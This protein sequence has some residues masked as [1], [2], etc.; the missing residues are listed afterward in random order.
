[1]FKIARP[2]WR[3]FRLA[4]AF[5]LIFTNWQILCWIDPKMI[6]FVL[7]FRPTC[8]RVFCDIS[9]EAKKKI[10][11][12]RL[13]YGKLLGCEIKEKLLPREGEKSWLH[14]S[15][16]LPNFFLRSKETKWVDKNDLS[17]W[18]RKWNL[19][20]KKWSKFCKKKK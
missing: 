5:K 18:K 13:I 10:R 19:I 20:K 1:M 16:S 9:I 14:L 12:R 15:H 3:K 17:F 6:K 8:R 2:R 11:R 4:K 7:T